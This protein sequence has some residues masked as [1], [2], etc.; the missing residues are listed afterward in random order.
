MKETR[1]K[2]TMI[3]LASS[4]IDRL[5]KSLKKK[6]KK[7]KKM[8]DKSTIRP[9]SVTKSRD[10]SYILGEY[11]WVDKCWNRMARGPERYRAQ[12]FEN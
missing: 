6:K 4:D 5:K 2:T 8:M 10:V 12:A 7:R 3:T 9:L 1:A 11:R